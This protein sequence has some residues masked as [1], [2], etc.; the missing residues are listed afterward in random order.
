MCSPR[1]V[2]MSNVKIWRLYKL[3]KNLLLFGNKSTSGRSPC[4]ENAAKCG[5]VLKRLRCGGENRSPKQF[6]FGNCHAAR[7]DF[8][9]KDRYGLR[10]VLCS[11]Y[12]N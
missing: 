9:G 8:A 12:S 5:F 11:K 6:R 7:A 4:P 3:I 1:R 2:F 10:R